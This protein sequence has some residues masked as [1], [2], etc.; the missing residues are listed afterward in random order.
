MSA[1]TLYDK[2][3]DAHVAHEAEDGT[4]LLYI[5]RH[6]VHEVTSPQAFEGLRMSGRKVRSP[7]KTIAVP[8]HNVP[9]TMGRENPAQM[10]EESRIQVEA[11]DKNAKDFGIHYYP[12]SDVRQGIVHIVG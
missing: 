11:L 7:D 1:K 4:C 8:D 9:T 3:W 5:D 10:T 12:V 6:L 2:I